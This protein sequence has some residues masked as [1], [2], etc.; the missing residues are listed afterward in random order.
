VVGRPGH[1]KGRTT[2]LLSLQGQLVGTVQSIHVIGR[3]EL[4]MAERAR[5]EYILLILMGERKTQTSPFVRAIWFPAIP[6]IRQP[7]RQ[8]Q[9]LMLRPSLNSSQSRVVDAIADPSIPLIVV[10]G[11]WSSSHPDSARLIPQQVR[12]ALGKRVRSLKLCA[13]VLPAA[14]AYGLQRSLMSR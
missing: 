5:D 1:A 6:R 2:E 13:N 3:E 7:E 14:T 12:L 10:Q 11:A 9:R 4:T 8:P